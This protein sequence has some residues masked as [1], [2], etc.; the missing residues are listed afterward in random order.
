MLFRD[1]ADAGRRLAFATRRYRDEAPVVLALP[2]GG[3][4]VAYQIARALSAPLDVWGARKIGAPGHQELGLGAVAE[5]GETYLNEELMDEIGVSPD[6]VADVV[7]RK[8]REM[9]AQVRR[10]RQGRP[11]PEIEGR[12]VILVDDGIAT[13]G[14]ARAALRALRRRR[15]GRLVLAI[16]VA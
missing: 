9:D 11:P 13:G 5:G 14:T 12:T 7:A 1:R 15:P 10:L 6:E 2:R 4:P 3:V 16:P 8:T